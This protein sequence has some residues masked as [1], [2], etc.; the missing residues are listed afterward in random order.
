MVDKKAIAKHIG[1]NLKRLRSSKGLSMQDLANLAELEK[2]QIV[3]IEN[4]QVDAKISSL[5]ILA[6]ALAVDVKEL[7]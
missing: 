1:S 4:G 5:Y 3:R 2:S 6:N 7:F